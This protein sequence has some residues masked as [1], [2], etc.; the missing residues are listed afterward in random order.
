MVLI[1]LSATDR[2]AD[3]DLRPLRSLTTR[4]RSCLSIIP[5]LVKKDNWLTFSV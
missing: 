4:D 5:L 2:F 3:M 1:F